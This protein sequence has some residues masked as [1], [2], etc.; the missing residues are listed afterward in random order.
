MVTTDTGHRSRL[1]L[2]PVVTFS[3]QRI[4]CSVHP[5][6]PLGHSA[7]IMNRVE[8]LDQSIGTNST[9]LPAFE[10]REDVDNDDGEMSP[11]NRD[12]HKSLEPSEVDVRQSTAEMRSEVTIR[13]DDPMPSIQS[14]HSETVR[15]S[16]TDGTHEGDGHTVIMPGDSHED[17]QSQINGHAPVALPD[18][19]SPVPDTVTD[20][21]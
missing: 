21:G 7:L 19:T 2:S 4:A 14:H 8:P 10:D 3:G 15:D 12:G 16:L 18:N 20:T 1:Q 17:G 11:Q 6:P 13:A 9:E 5:Q